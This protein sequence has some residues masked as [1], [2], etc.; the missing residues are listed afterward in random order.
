MELE[1]RLEK[2]I[3]CIITK[4]LTVKLTKDKLGEIIE[5]FVG[6]STRFFQILDQSLKR[7]LDVIPRNMQRALDEFWKDVEETEDIEEL[8]VDFDRYAIHHKIMMLK[9]YKVLIKL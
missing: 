8:E 2:V 3:E 1:C 7:H 6:K 9:F 5:S 4:K